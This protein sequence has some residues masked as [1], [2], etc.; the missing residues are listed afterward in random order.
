MFC[1][2]VFLLL[3]DQVETKKSWDVFSGLALAAR[4]SLSPLGSAVAGGVFQLYS[5]PFERPG[6]GGHRGEERLRGTFGLF[7]HHGV[8]C[9]GQKEGT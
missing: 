5:A 1:L 2:L 7:G 3:F 9:L 6:Q 8:W 4:S